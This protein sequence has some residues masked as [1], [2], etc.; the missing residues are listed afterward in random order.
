[1]SL[2][3]F[4]LCASPSALRLAALTFSLSCRAADRFRR[5]S[6]LAAGGVVACVSI[7]FSCYAF[8]HESWWSVYLVSKA[9][10]SRARACVLTCSVPQISLLWGVH[11]AL[12][13]APLEALFADAVP[14]LRRSGIFAVK[15]SLLLFSSSLG[16]FLS[17]GLFYFMGDRW[18][19]AVLERVLTIGT[20][21][22]IVPAIS[23]FFFD[24]ERA[25]RDA[26]RELAES[27]AAPV[28]AEREQARVVDGETASAAVELSTR[29]A[30][31]KDE[32]SAP[33]SGAEASIAVAATV[34]TASEGGPESRLASLW[35][36]LR[37]EAAVAYVLAG[38]DV[39]TAVGAGMTVQ[40]FPVF[41]LEVAGLSPSEFSFGART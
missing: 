15:H 20:V 36:T 41:F 16:P 25:A 37:S 34:G 32:S 12:T 11:A 39:V 14:P 9:H 38:V 28:T 7:A 1:M 24:D 10:A 21:L 27:Q 40:F 23:L 2:L 17:V 3:L 8:L 4:V 26:Q 22:A 6:V 13:N 30:L 33:A 35:R 19:P 31:D 5:H 29:T 18:D